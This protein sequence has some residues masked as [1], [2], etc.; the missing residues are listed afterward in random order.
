VNSEKTTWGLLR[1]FMVGGGKLIL[2]SLLLYTITIG[3]NLFP[4]LFQQ[5]F[6]DHIITGR[7]PDWFWP[8]ILLYS[9]LFLLELVA[10]LVLNGHRRKLDMRFS[11]VS[12]ARYIWHALRLPMDAHQRFSSGDLIARYMGIGTTGVKLFDMAPALVL[13]FNVLIFSY[14]LFVYHWKLGLIEIAAL[15]TIALSI[16]LTMG[17]QKR[18]ARSMEATERHL[19]SATMAGMHSMETIKAAGAEQ[20]F[21]Q[22]WES[23]YTQALNARVTVTRQMILMGALPLLVQQL[24][25]ALLLCLGAWFILKGELTPGMLLAS[26]GF[27]SVMLFPIT[28]MSNVMQDI[29]RSH[30]ML[31]RQEEVLD[32]EVNSEERIVN[33]EPLKGE[34]ELRNVTFG[35][36]RSMPPL[37]E[38]LSLRIKP[39]EQVAFVGKSGCGK[40][41]LAMLVAGLYEPWEG[42]IFL[43]GKPIS[44]TS[45]ATLTG[46]IGV[47]G[48]DVT[49]FE[50]TIA[51]NI[52]MWDESITDADVVRAATCAQLHQEITDMPNTYDSLVE[53]GGQNFSSGQ[54]QRLEIAAALAKQPTILI[55]DE[56]TATLDIATEAAIIQDVRKLGITLLMIAHRLET[57]RQCD[58]IY[59]IEHGH[60][61]Q[62]GSH[63]QLMAD[64]QGLYYQLNTY[65][66]DD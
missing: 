33:S 60:V 55:L 46:S 37:I 18:K 38:H 14:L 51:D 13:L 23:L 2:I 61:I 11:L 9:G 5:V 43:D 29:F 57:V 25:A 24:T 56:A 16:R 52:R 62:H 47:V 59:V 64:T 22:K 17:Y 26:Q 32:I 20:R 65:G 19:Q 48:Q 34:I 42:E 28:K 40:S 6:T 31:E 4:P 30:S 49:L 36:D 35:Y 44:Q 53:T 45:R 7:N 58:T 1:R 54:R 3:M 12:Q 27:M 50:G 63:D 39:G 8:L 15:L 66:N 41:T 21:Y 10:W